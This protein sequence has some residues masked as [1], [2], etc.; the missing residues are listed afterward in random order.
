MLTISLYINNFSD[1]HKKQVDNLR[2]LINL[3]GSAQVAVWLGYSDT[4]PIH[5]WLSR[6]Q[7]PEKKL[8]SV[9]ELLKHKGVRHVRDRK[10]K[11]KKTS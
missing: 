7:I 11:T 1:M 6:G 3:Y 10:R 5:Q 2:K 4:R 9:N 8:G